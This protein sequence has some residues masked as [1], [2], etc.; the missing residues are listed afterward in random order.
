MGFYNTGD[1]KGVY[2]IDTIAYVADDDAGLRIINVS[3]PA[4]PVETGFYDTGGFAYGVF[5]IDTIAYVADMQAGLRIINVSDHSLPVEIGFYDMG[6]SAY[7]VYVIDTIAYV[8]DR[9]AGLYII[10]V[11][12]SGSGI[13]DNKLP[14][15]VFNNNYYIRYNITT[16]DIYFGLKERGKLILDIYDKIGRKLKTLYNSIV[17]DGYTKISI[18]KLDYITGEYFIKGKMGETEI[19]TKI[20]IIK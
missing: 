20:M 15:K 5:V 8:A 10:K 13:E 1:A 14:D 7:G 17:E 4:L 2:V 11:P 3:N 18:N 9:Y 16:I 12:M 19:N 6:G